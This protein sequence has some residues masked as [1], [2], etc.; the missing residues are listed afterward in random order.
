MG[1]NVHLHHHP[2]ICVQDWEFWDPQPPLVLTMET[3]NPGIPKDPVWGS[4]LCSLF[5]NDLEL[6]LKNE[7]T[8]FAYDTKLLSSGVQYI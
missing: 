4:L 3:P 5:I 7:G 1:R 2:W 8:P 6:G